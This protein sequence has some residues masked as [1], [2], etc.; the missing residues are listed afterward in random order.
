MMKHI[1]TSEPVSGDS[2]LR[3]PAAVDP[4]GADG[5]GRPLAVR[6][7][8]VWSDFVRE[9]ARDSEAEAPPRQKPAVPLIDDMTGILQWE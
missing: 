8:D 3:R 1:Q 7:D 9:S 5:G 2:E 4:S 6:L